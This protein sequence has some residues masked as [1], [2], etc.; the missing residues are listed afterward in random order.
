MRSLCD[1]SQGIGSDGSKVAQLYVLQTIFGMP[2]L[3]RNR[4]ENAI[5]IFFDQW[6]AE[7][8]V[9]IGTGPREYPS[10]NLKFLLSSLYKVTE[11]RLPPYVQILVTHTRLSTYGSVINHPTAPMEVRRFF[12]TAGLSSALNVMRVAIQGESQLQ[13]MPNNTA[14]MI[15][16]A[17]CFALTLSAYATGTS[18]LAPSIRK[19]ID[20]TGGVLERVGTVTEHRN[21][22]SVLYGKHLRHLVKKSGGDGSRQ[23]VLPTPEAPPPQSS[24]QPLSLGAT[25]SGPSTF[26]DQHLLWPETLQLSTMSDDQ[27]TQVLNQS[28]NE[29]EPSFGGLSWEDMN[30]FDWL[31]WPE[32]GPT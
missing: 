31:Y 30:N 8:G 18:T 12:R 1:G 27:I 28:G 14:I 4:I 24:I 15:S 13:S 11:H 29:F 20:E 32:F 10:G 25:V 2:I 23:A 22:L 7:W 19:L 17:A 6:Y 16:F 5:E 21:G 26:M 9:S 3:T